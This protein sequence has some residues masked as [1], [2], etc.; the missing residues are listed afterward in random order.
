MKVDGQDLIQGGVPKEPTCGTC[1]FFA[2]KEPTKK[3][4]NRIGNCRFHA[5]QEDGHHA[6]FD[7]GWCG[8]YKVDENKI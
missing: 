2:L 6:V 7:S 1:M 8:D 5:S 3:L 4:H